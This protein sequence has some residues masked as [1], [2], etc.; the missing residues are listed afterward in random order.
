MRRIS[1]SC[2]IIVVLIVSLSGCRLLQHRFR[3]WGGPVAPI[4]AWTSSRITTTT[5]V[6]PESEETALTPANVNSTKF[7]KLGELP[8]GWQGCPA[9]LSFPGDHRGQ[10]KNVLYVATEHRFRLRNRR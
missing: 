2:S 1:I 9:S 4:Q 3:K 7:G 5:S 6:L 10:K 8:V